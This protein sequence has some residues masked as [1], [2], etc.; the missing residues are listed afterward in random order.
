MLEPLRWALAEMLP[1]PAAG[2]AEAEAPDEK[3]EAQARLQ[4]SSCSG[5]HLLPSSLLVCGSASW[6]LDGEASKQRVAALLN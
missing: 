2:G 1:W 3:R 5:P 6:G 4:C